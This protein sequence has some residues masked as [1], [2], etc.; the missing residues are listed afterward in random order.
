MNARGHGRQPKH[1]Q[2][3][4]RSAQVTTFFLFCGFATLVKPRSSSPFSRRSAACCHARPYTAG[5]LPRRCRAWLY[6]APAASPLYVG[7]ASVPAVGLCYCQE[8]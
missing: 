7:C 8:V 2:K 5:A 4:T 3:S 1:K 6:A